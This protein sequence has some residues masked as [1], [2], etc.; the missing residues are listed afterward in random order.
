M[1]IPYDPRAK[2]KALADLNNSGIKAYPHVNPGVFLHSNTFT[3]NTGN[4]YPLGGNSN[5][6]KILNNE[7]KI[8]NIESDSAWFLTNCHI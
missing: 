3:D 8:N 1:G 4:I 2:I 6:I 7:Y 5:N